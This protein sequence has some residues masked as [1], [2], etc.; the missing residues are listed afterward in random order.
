M[1]L[2]FTIEDRLEYVRTIIEV[3]NM[4][5]DNIAP[6]LSFFW[7]IGTNFY[8]KIAKIRAGRRMWAKLMKEQYQLQNSKPFL[9]R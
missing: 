9:L 4:K 6:K 8:T 3:T 1:K 5:V 2:V 7:G